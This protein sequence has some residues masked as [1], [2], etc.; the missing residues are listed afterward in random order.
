[1]PIIMINFELFNE[2]F[3]YSEIHRV[4]LWTFVIRSLLMFSRSFV[5]FGMQ[6]ALHVVLVFLYYS[7]SKSQETGIGKVGKK[8]FQ[9]TPQRYSK[10]SSLFRMI[11]QS[12]ISNKVFPVRVASVT[13]YAYGTLRV[14]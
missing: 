9:V 12:C 1:M 4:K 6:R 8:L 2:V 13:C 10:N 14:P 3:L 11:F 7:L 5:R